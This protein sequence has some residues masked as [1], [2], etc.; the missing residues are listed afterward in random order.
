M[1]T[2]YKNGQYDPGS[3]PRPFSA[4]T[5]PNE[6]A[7]RSGKAPASAKPAPSVPS[8]VNYN[9]AT[10]IST[11]GITSI[12]KPL[13]PEAYA[14]TPTGYSWKGYSGEGSDYINKLGAPV[15]LS[16]VDPKSQFLTAKQR[17]D[18][19]NWKSGKTPPPVFK[20]ET[21]NASSPSTSPISGLTKVA[22]GSV[23]P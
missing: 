3:D 12:P 8:G 9:P 5:D 17:D 20:P 10:N 14:A 7:I 22:T 23:G 18:Y 4:L 1:A 15:F 19:D 11:T 6:I 13:P 2:Y 21:G 16:K